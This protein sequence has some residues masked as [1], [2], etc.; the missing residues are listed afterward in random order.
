[1]PPLG[2][3]TDWEDPG[4]QALVN[5]YLAW[6]APRLLMLQDIDDTQRT[7]LERHACRQAVELAAVFRLIPRILDRDRIEAARVEAALRHAAGGRS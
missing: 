6:Q 2:L 3:R 5:D 1:M 4:D 7:W